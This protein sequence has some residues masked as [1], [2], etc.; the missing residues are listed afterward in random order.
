M[1][2]TIA[3]KILAARSGHD[4]VVPG[5]LIECATDWVLCHE[6]TTPAAR[7]PATIL[8]ASSPS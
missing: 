3:E 2:M 8:C 1:G 6:I 7:N 4:R 5:Q